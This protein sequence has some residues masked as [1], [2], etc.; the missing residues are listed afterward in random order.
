MAETDFI[1]MSIRR[2]IGEEIRR[3][4]EATGWTRKEFA[5]RLPFDVHVQSIAGYEG[6]T[7]QCT[8]ARFVELCETL[9]VSAPDLI[10]WAM[11][12]AKVSLPLIGIQVDLH[13][14]IA[15]K[16]KELLA[17]RRWARR[18]LEIDDSNGVARLSW[19]TVQEMG[20]MFGFGVYDFVKRVTA[21]TPQ[22]VPHRR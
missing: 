1:D 8:T 9:G 7:V 20:Y 3:A 2:A 13:A 19:E 22:P 11:Q 17:L 5:E 6:G 16:S 10:A 15:D 4:R 14:V 18:R 21:F 12:R